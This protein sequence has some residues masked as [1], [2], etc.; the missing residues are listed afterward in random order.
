MGQS[1]YNP[2]TAASLPPPPI[3]SRHTNSLSSQDPLTRTAVIS[4]EPSPSEY[5]PDNEYAG[6][7]KNGQAR[8]PYGQYLA[9]QAPPSH[10]WASQHPDHQN[11]VYTGYDQRQSGYGEYVNTGGY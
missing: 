3:R 1:E 10:G 8:D 7:P 6:Y 2:A 11:A 5:F 9:P 4:R